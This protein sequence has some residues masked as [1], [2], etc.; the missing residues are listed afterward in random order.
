LD[1]SNSN[2]KEKKGLESKDS[3]KPNKDFAKEDV[4]NEVYHIGLTI[5]LKI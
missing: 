3:I 1:F 5:A 2:S 4:R